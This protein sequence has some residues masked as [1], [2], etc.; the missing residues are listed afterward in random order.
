MAFTWTTT[1]QAGLEN[2]V[3]IFVYGDSGAGKT[4]L[5]TTAPRPMIISAENR[6]VSIRQSVIPAAI[7]RS[8]EDARDVL[9][10]IRSSAEAAQFDTVCCDSATEI[11]EV[12]LQQLKAREKDP[13]KAYGAVQDTMLE[14]LREFRDLP[15]KHVCVIAKMIY[16]RDE[17]AGTMRFMPLMTGA[18]LGPQIPYLFDEVFRMGL[19]RDP[20][21]QVVH[22]FLQTQGDLQY[23]A[24][25]SSGAL[26]PMEIPDLSHIIGKILGGTQK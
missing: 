19:W 15:R 11:S 13:R 16:E 7:I 10:W 21:T 9:R 3:K 2:G 14:L 4:R 17:A 12:L 5:C 23:V 24:K 25:D 1:Q 18:K 26:S 22:P 6:F 20:A 8:V